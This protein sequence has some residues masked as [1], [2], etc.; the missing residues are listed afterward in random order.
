V[1]LGDALS[2]DVTPIARSGLFIESQPGRG[3]LLVTAVLLKNAPPEPLLPLG[4][5]VISCIDADDRIP[6]PS[7][8]RLERN[9]LT[10]PVGELDNSLPAAGAPPPFVPSSLI[11][12]VRSTPRKP[13]ARSTRK[14][15]GEVKREDGAAPSWGG[16]SDESTELMELC[17][18][19][20]R[21]SMPADH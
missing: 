15:N 18:F 6:L 7:P 19:F 12:R 5:A 2:E 13:R 3:G 1:K 4:S 17:L 8:P 14:L 10:D 11:V 16:C 9:V 20:L 21:P